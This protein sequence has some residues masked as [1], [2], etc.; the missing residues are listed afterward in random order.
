MF[1]S[2]IPPLIIT[3][4]AVYGNTESVAEDE[5][6]RMLILIRNFIPGWKQIVKGAW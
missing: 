4:P 1:K 6:M 2:D 3:A 5:V